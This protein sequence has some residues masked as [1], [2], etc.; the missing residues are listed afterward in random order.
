MNKERIIMLSDCQSFY[1]SVEKAA[2][3]QYNGKPLAVAGDPARRSG[4]I[5]AACPLA[6][7]QGVSTAETLKEALAKCPE[8]IVVRPRMQHYIDV[9][10]QITGILRTFSDLVEPYSIDEQFID[11]T[12]SIS[13]FGSPQQIAAAIQDQ[14][15]KETGV[16]ARIGISYS[17]VTAKMACD[18][19]AKKIKGGLFTLAREQLP[20]LLWPQPIG[21]LF[22]VGRRMSAHFHS[23]GL[24]TIGHLAQMPLAELK[25]RM[26][27][28][29]HKNCD[30]DAELYW[31]IAGG[32]DD[33]PVHPATYEAPPKSVGHQMTLPRD[34]YT[35]AEIKTVLL[36]LAELVCRRCRRLA[37]NGAVVS[38]G[39]QGA[40]FEAPTGFS[41]QSKMSDPT[42]ATSLVYE[43]AVALFRRHWDGQ[44]V[45]RVNLSLSELSDEN[46]YQLTLFESRPRYRELER[47]TDNLKNKYGDTIIGRAASF[48]D[49]GLIK[50]RAGKI[51]GHYK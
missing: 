37:V 8:L 47:A 26:R 39:C 16:Y 12:G 42:N 11:I 29:F 48:T 27:E 38:V 19:W 44:P 18:L 49:S 4:I 22:M 25:W 10:A 5:L 34:Y 40:S 31:R 24:T 9:S 35:L 33:S 21:N 15:S 30:I 6:K 45:R 46:Q 28:K 20:E 1:A 36:E 23:M 2:N 32:L 51:G 17:K 14:I 13:L 41:R 50:D 7:Q 43:A 3:P